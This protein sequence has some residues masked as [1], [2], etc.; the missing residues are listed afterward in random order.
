MC[1]RHTRWAWSSSARHADGAQPRLRAVARAASGDVACALHRVAVLATISTFEDSDSWTP[2]R[3]DSDMAA[4]LRWALLLP[5]QLRAVFGWRY[6]LGVAWC[7]GRASNTQTT[8]PRMKHKAEKLQ[9]LKL[10][11]AF[12]GRASRVSPSGSS[13]H[14]CATWETALSC[15]STCA[16]FATCRL[17]FASTQH[18]AF[19]TRYDF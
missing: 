10:R 12:T 1:G 16:S 9:R 6:S 3:V 15:T 7:K 4:K 11:A 5:R 2:R 14:R 19:T 17:S 18:P 8:G 13:R